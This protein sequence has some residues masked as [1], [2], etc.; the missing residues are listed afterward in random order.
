ME[1][2]PD[3]HGRIFEDS[4][5]IVTGGTT[6]IGRAIVML[7]VQRGA[8]V[9]YFGRHEKEINEVT[10]ELTKMSLQH[11]AKGIIADVSK[12]EDIT[13]IFREADDFLGRPDILVNNAALGYQGV[14][15]GEYEDWQYILQVNMLGYMA[16]AHEAASRMKDKGGGHIINIGSMSADKR[17]EGSSVYVATKAG[18]QGFSESLRKELNPLGIK[19]TLIEP[20]AVSTDMQPGTEH[21]KREKEKNMKMLKPEDIAQCVLYVLIQPKRCDVVEVKIRPHLQLI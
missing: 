17:E 11:N 16:C 13:Y 3:I 5:A 9:L 6:G 18:I 21:D 2:A 4:T 12:K 8:K 15:D 20:G 1:N 19:V 14:M 10:E 7:L